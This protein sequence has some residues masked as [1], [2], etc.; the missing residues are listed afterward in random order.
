[1]NEKQMLLLVDDFLNFLDEVEVDV[2]GMELALLL[3]QIE[4]VEKRNK[5]YEKV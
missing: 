4:K 2:E 1:M 5:I 3:E